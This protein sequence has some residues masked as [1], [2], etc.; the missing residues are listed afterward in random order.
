MGKK[1]RS[2]VLRFFQRAAYATTK[3]VYEENVMKMKNAGGF[4]AEFFLR[5]TPCEMW[6]NA[7]FKG[8]RY[9]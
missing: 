2:M 5:D 3:L 8:K 4:R 1:N 6:A 9:G 7:Y